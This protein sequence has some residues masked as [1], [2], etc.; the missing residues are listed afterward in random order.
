MHRSAGLPLLPALLLAGVILVSA[1]LALSATRAPAEPYAW[2]NVALR[3]GGYVTGIQFHPRE[4]GLLYT[5]TDVGGAY[6]WLP[7]HRSWIA[8]NDGIDRANNDL[9]AVISLALDPRDPQRVYLACGAYFSEWARKAAVLRSHDRGASWEAVDLPVK[10]GG[11]QD[12][13][14]MGERLQVDPNDGDILY[15]G[16]NQDGLWRSRDGAR[17]WSRVSTFGPKGV[18]FVLFDPRS[19]QDGKPSSTLYAGSADSARPVIYRSTDAGKSWAPL[20]GQPNGLLVHHAAID[21]TG[22]VYFALANALGPNGA[23]DGALWKFEPSSDRWTDLSPARPNPAAKDT[24]GYAGLALDPTQPGTLYVSTLNR[25]TLGDEIY[26]STDGGATWVPLLAHSHL[27]PAGAPYLR[28]MKPHWISDLAVDPTHPERLWFVTGYGVWATEQARA[29]VA[30]GAR[31]TWFFAN[32][33]LEETVID[34]LVSP[35][36]GAP[37]L[38][39]VGDLG[40]FRHDKL[41]VSPRGGMFEP[42]HGGNPGIDFAAQ[43]PSL[44][45]RTHWGPAR[46]ALSRDGGTT[47]ENFPSAPAAAAKH[48][49][50]IVAISA[51]GQR[52]VWLPKGAKPHYSTDLGRTWHESRSALVATTQWTT[53]GP[54]ADRVNPLRFSIYDPLNGALFVSTDGGESFEKLKSLPAG[55]SRLRAEPGVEGGL[56]LPS[57]EGL[58]VSQDGGK[59]FRKIPGVGSAHQVGFGAPA[60]GRTNA[61]VFLDGTVRGE[62]AFFRSDDRGETW[63]RI[64]DERMR[65]G[66]LRCLTGDARVHGRVYLGTSGRG[67]VVGEPLPGSK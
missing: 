65:L 1:P 46:G 37:L 56:W 27:N 48:G 28:A 16:T 22:A 11:N 66:W 63:I 45:V 50:G 24:F 35:P 13:R 49:P 32:Q 42:F 18:T 17:T 61:A 60:P 23:T 12:G 55:N 43:V 47:W 58:H 54:V 6:R 7:E 39:A 36:E 8:L 31:L 3:G 30:Q 10:L 15:L 21:P 14:G 62:S 52:L 34:E 20:A 64:S 53:Y 9:Y 40:G 44:V 67:I 59:S 25:W 19:G 5:R 57:D 2:R 51:D 29:E 26:R 38:S 41:D 4:P 33:G